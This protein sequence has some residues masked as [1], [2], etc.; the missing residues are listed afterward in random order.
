MEFCPSVTITSDM[1]DS[2]KE[3][4]EPLFETFFYFSLAYS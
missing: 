1:L 2:P 4:Q 3:T